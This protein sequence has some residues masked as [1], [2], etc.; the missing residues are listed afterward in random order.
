MVDN[1]CS[2]VKQKNVLSKYRVF[3]SL[4]LLKKYKVSSV[5][6]TTYIKELAAL[7]SIFNEI[8]LNQKLIIMN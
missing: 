8:S 7:N 6:T 5:T 2:K 3:C 1:L 4:E